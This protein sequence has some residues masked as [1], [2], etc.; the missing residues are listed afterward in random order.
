MARRQHNQLLRLTKIGTLPGGSTRYHILYSDLHRILPL[1]APLY[2]DI[3][4]VSRTFS[5]IT[6]YDIT[7]GGEVAVMPIV[8]SQWVMTLPGISIVSP[9]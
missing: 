6:H 1:C 3:T 9:L 7:M 2:L 4:P 8:I 5:S